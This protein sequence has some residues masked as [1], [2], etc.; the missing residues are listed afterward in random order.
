[1][2]VTVRG[3]EYPG[4][5]LVADVWDA[6]YGDP[7]AGDAMFRVVLLDSAGA[8]LP[9]QLRDSRIGVLCWAEGAAQPDGE[10][11]SRAA[12]PA[13]DAAGG[14]HIERQEIA[15][16]VAESRV[17]HDAR[18]AAETPLHSELASLREAR[19]RFLAGPD[20]GLKNLAHAISKREMEAQRELARQAAAR[21]SGGR[22]VLSETARFTGHWQEDIPFIG[23]DPRAWLEA[24]AAVLLARAGFRPPASDAPPLD[25]VSLAALWSAVAAGRVA[26]AVRSIDVRFPALNAAPGGPSVLSEIDDLLN[27]A[28][29]E[30]AG[31]GLRRRLVH[32]LGIPP[33]IAGVCIAAHIAERDSEASLSAP[34]AQAAS[35]LVADVPRLVRDHLSGMPYD[36]GLLGRVTALR[37][38]VTGDWDSALPYVRLALPGARPSAQGGGDAFDSQSFASA[39]ESLESKFALSFGVLERLEK[40]LG[41]SGRAVNVSSEKLFIVLSAESWQEFFRR[42]RAEFG[43]VA[44]LKSALD[45]AQRLRRAGEDAL[46]IER[47]A[48]Y[49]DAADFGRSDQPLALEAETLRARIALPAILGNPSLWPPLQH[50]FQNWRRR[51]QRAYL[52]FHAGRREAARHLLRQAGEGVR[53]LTA[54]ERFSQIPELGPP[55]DPTLGKRWQEVASAVQECPAPEEEI[56]LADRPQCATCGARM[57]ASLDTAE[58]EKT[59]AEI[60]AQVTACNARLG[61]ATVREV[62]AGR[63]RDEVEKLL[64]INAAGDLSTLSGVL[65]DDVIAFLRQFLRGAGASERSRT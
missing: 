23:D 27:A 7:L 20:P 55:A 63:R 36:G 9:S 50:D 8:P 56:S 30:V 61:D 64:Q 48:A 58:F 22:F 4:E 38:H 10:E 44:T 16:R 35:S 37:P 13:S 65:S 3:V 51:Y 54:A 57:G 34:P 49:L 11:A 60:K 29:K 46:E 28:G 24:A 5:V 53:L 52:E 19:R 31:E 6:R 21:W 33:A 39:I 2:A 14:P 40:R 18:P 26:E 43:S 42:A 12:P 41:Q 45:M 15:R 17:L 25:A 62:L 47:C 1:V 32:E 59:L